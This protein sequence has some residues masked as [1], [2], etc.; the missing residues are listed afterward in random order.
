MKRQAIALLVILLMACTSGGSATSSG[1]EDAAAERL[2]AV[3]VTV[4]EQ[5]D[6]LTEQD[7]ALAE[8]ESMLADH[9]AEL[10]ALK[11]RVKSLE[12]RED[13]AAPSVPLT[14]EEIRQLSSPEEPW[15]LHPRDGTACLAYYDYEVEGETVQL[16]DDACV[17]IPQGSDGDQFCDLVGSLRA[18]YDDDPSDLDRFVELYEQMPQHL[19]GGAVRWPAEA[20]D[21]IEYLRS[22]GG[23]DS[24]Y[25][26]YMANL[27]GFMELACGLAWSDAVIPEL[28]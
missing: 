20:P 16:A 25:S 1:S 24:N 4:S 8:Q 19:S 10:K 17:P 11:R 14:E 28:S 15:F 21:M 6:A 18:A 2:D 22:S 3:L 9:A 5:S 7:G 27:S 13:V 26:L 23:G 12:A